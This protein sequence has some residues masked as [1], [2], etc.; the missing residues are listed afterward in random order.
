MQDKW[1]SS[2]QGKWGRW[3]SELSCEYGDVIFG[4]QAKSEVYQGSNDDTAGK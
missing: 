1:I 3:E 4:A 2:K